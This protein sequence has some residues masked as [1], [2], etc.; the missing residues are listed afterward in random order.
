MPDPFPQAP[1]DWDDVSF[2]ITSGRVA[3]YLEGHRAGHY[4]GWS[5][6]FEA[7]AASARAQDAEFAR[8]VEQEYHRRELQGE[9]QK[10]LVKRLIESARTEENRQKYPY[11]FERRNAA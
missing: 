4:A 7:G 9:I 10:A 8:L 11:P 3:G 6:G 5:A 2:G 1:S